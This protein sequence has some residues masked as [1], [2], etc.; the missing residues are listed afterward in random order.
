MVGRFEVA[1]NGTIF[2][3]EV[4]DLPPG[5]QAK[6]LRVLQEGEFERLGSTNTIKVSVRL[7][8]ATNRDLVK[9]VEA[10]TFR[11]DLFYRLN[12]FQI[13]VPSL[14]DRKET[15]PDLVWYFVAKYQDLLGKRVEVIP[16]AVMNALVSYNWPGNVRELENQIQSA[17][18]LSP[19]RV[20]M[21]DDSWTKP[22]PDVSPATCES[23]AATERAH[24]IAILEST[25]WKLKGK[26][27]AAERLGMN[28]STLRSRMKKLGIHRPC[29]SS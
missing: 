1:H 24:I 20:L 19:G 12:V 6:L 26:N 25:G 21:L 7:V 14:R 3:D 11:A 9:M 16:K 13:H 10:G 17:L 28:P 27:N 29:R 8:A 22:V 4:G 5:L 15:I 23:L 18:I 2:L